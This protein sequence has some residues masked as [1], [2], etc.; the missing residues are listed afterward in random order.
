MHWTGFDYERTFPAY[1][2]CLTGAQHVVVH[3][4]HDLRENMRDVRG[5]PPSPYA[6]HTAGRNSWSIGIAVAAMADATPADFG[7]YPITAAQVDALCIVA[8]RL[9]ALYGIAVAAI[10]THAEA[11]LDDGYFGDGEGARWDIARLRASRKPLVP[12]EATATGDVFRARIA[13]LLPRAR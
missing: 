4:T 7:A 9:A 13:M 12:A 11:A 8:A 6:A 3:H 2:W 1:H 10:R 5:V